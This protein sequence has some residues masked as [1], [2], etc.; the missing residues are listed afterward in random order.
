MIRP[1]EGLEDTDKKQWIDEI[2]GEAK[3]RE[4][5][6]EELHRAPPLM[7]LGSGL[8]LRELSPEEAVL[9]RDWSFVARRYTVG[10]EGLLVSLFEILL[11]RDEYDQSDEDDA[12]TDDFLEGLRGSTQKGS[13][14]QLL[15]LEPD[16]TNTTKVLPEQKH[17]DAGA[18]QG[19]GQLSV[20]DGQNSN[21]NGFPWSWTL[22]HNIVKA[23][24]T[25]QERD[26]DQNRAL[27][28]RCTTSAGVQQEF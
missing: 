18:A 28:V 23:P 26:R 22:W 25:A 10:T 6:Q 14:S 2:M 4:A 15:R 8:G 7:R 1:P 17:G 27:F 20:T 16:G 24:A 9:D 12:Q 13:T 5:R 21:R 11:V 3:D 19:Q